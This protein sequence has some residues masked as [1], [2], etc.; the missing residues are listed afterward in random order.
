MIEFKNVSFSFPGTP[1]LEN[2]SFSMKEGEFVGI[3]GPNGGG[4]ST[5]LNLAL[6][7]LKPTT[8]EIIRP[9][10]GVAYIIAKNRNKK[11]SL[12]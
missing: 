5:F 9:K 4:K 2:V 11:Y 10:K 1:V 8:G 6:G 7:L 3:L 12:L